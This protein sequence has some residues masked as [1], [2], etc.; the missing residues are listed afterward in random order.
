MQLPMIIGEQS[1]MKMG[2]WTVELIVCCSL[3][4]LTP[5]QPQSENSDV[6]DLEIGPISEIVLED[7]G[8]SFE[9]PFRVQNIS[10]APLYVPNPLD[11]F[12]SYPFRFFLMSPDQHILR[13]TKMERVPFL[14][15]T[16]WMKLEAN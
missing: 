10:H 1:I 14:L 8:W 6:L 2:E 11:V 9:L 12:M 7:R 5:L 15:E 4:L 16:A 13:D 3:L